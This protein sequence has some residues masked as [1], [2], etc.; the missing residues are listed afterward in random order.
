VRHPGLATVYDVVSEGPWL[1]TILEY[2]EG[3]E[4]TRW[5]R[6]GG[7][8]LQEVV[9]LLK[10]LAEALDHLHAQSIVHRDLKPANV[11]VRPDGRPVLLDL[12]IAKDLTGQS[13]GHTRTMTAMGT[14]AW[15]APEQADAKRVTGAADVYAFGL[16]AYALLSGR[17]PWGSDATEGRIIANKLMGQLVPLSQAAAHL[18]APLS[19]AVMAAVSVS[20]E[21]RPA[22]CSAFVRALEEGPRRAREVE[23]ARPR[24]E[25][26]ERARR[27][28]E[29][30]K[31]RQ[32]EEKQEAARQKA[33]AEA[34]RKAEETARRK[35]KAEA[36]RKQQA[37]GR[38]QALPV[39]HR[40]HRAIQ[41]T[42]EV[43]VSE[44]FLGFGRKVAH[45]N[46]TAQIAF[47]LVRLAPGHFRRETSDVRL[48]HGFSMGV[49]AVTQDL[50][51]AVMGTNPSA[52]KGGLRPVEQ[53]SWYDAVRFCN[54]LSAACGLQAAYTIGSG[55]EPSV[56]CDFRAHG[57][58][59]P[60]EA[61]WEYAARA[62]QDFEY[63]GSNELDKV[64]WY[65]NNSSG[66][67]HPV[68]QK[69]PNAWGLYDMSG[70][71]WEWCWDRYG[72]YPNKSQNDP[73][74]PDFGDYRVRRGGSW[75]S[76]ARLCRAAYRSWFVPGDRSVYLGFRLVLPVA[77]AGS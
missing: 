50:Y 6:P 24:A 29:E 38:K 5:V 19:E 67:T 2:V 69:K 23:Q 26:A 21:D 68:G 46:Y 7:L 61:E 52:F 55:G 12:G 22:S 74:G 42:R 10:P 43:V 72:D 71:V 53:A 47:D 4:L 64:G 28:E 11:K 41:G 32:E 18:P 20:P 25:A 39:P 27:R 14:S 44:G 51:E 77:P 37:A 59:L 58:R 54:A 40:F 35:A 63:A 70:N 33:K 56:S 76:Y 9:G 15:M 3:E 73:Y 60:T 1:G 13:G 30:A 49:H 36:R 31:R 16:I 65:I 8:G 75:S 48:T 57:F 17:M 62:G 66:H 45:E 34:R